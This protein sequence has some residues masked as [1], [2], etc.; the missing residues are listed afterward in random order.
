MKCLSLQKKD[1]DGKAL[2]YP[3]CG[4][5]PEAKSSP[6]LLWE[7]CAA[8]GGGKRSVLLPVGKRKQGELLLLLFILLEAAVAAVPAREGGTDTGNSFWYEF[9]PVLIPV[10]FAI[11]SKTMKKSR[12]GWHTLTEYYSVAFKLNLS[13]II[14]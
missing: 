11:P 13:Q 10:L 9:F 7:S 1:D 12:K 5:P 2:V 4:F 3:I 6:V 8:S 14:F